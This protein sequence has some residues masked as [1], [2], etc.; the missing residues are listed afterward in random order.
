MS[1]YSDDFLDWYQEYP[2]HEGKRDAMKAWGKASDSDRIAALADVQKR[3][4]YKAWSTNKKLIPLPATYLRGARFEDDW[5]STFESSQKSDDDRPNSGLVNYVSPDPG[6]ECTKWQSLANRWFLRWRRASGGLADD[7]LK[8]G[9]KI[10]N[11]V[12][13]ELSAGLDEELMLNDGD[14]ETQ[15]DT[16]WTFLNVMIDRLDA[17]LNRN[18][19]GLLINEGSHT[20]PQ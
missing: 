14:R 18:L 17:D 16:C 12:V 11:E 5:F 10:K 19:K 8:T 9:V 15:I 4:R 3:N 6:Y 20:Q 1:E 13:T 7:E 2:R